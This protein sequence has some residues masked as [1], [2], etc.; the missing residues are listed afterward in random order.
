MIHARDAWDITTGSRK[1]T[2]GVLDTGIDHRHPDLENNLFVNPGEIPVGPSFPVKRRLVDTNGDGVIT[3]GDLNHPDNLGKV[4]GTST[5]VHS[6]DLID[7][8]PTFKDHEG[9]E[10]TVGGKSK[11]WTVLA[12][13]PKALPGG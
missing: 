1:V 2:I 8:E 9:K 12:F 5:E 3:F 11:T 10:V 4:P 7:G 13:Y 6:V